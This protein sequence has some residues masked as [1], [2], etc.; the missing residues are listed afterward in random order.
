M[1]GIQSIDEIK[2]ALAVLATRADC[3]HCVLKNICSEMLAEECIRDSAEL[4]LH[5]IREVER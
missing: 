2:Q 3:E 5:V 4:Y 1:T